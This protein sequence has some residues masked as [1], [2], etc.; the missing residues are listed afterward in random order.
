MPQEITIDITLDAPIDL[1]WQAWT[2]PARM[3]WFGS[4]PEGRVVSQQQIDFQ[5]GV[6]KRARN[7]LPGDGFPASCRRRG[8]PNAFFPRQ[9]VGRFGA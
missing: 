3:T 7:V 6:G 9:S 5:L 8:H 1:V 2:D 4:D